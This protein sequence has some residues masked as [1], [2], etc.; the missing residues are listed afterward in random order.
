MFLFTTV[1]ACRSQRRAWQGKTVALVPTMGALHE[2]HRALIRHA[3]SV[4]DVVVVSIFVNPLQF[5]P[6]EDLAAYPRPKEQDLAS[7]EALGVDAVFYPSPL[8]MYPDGP[9]SLTRVVPPVSMTENF[10]GAFRPGHFEGVATVVLKLFSIVQPDVA[11]FGEKDAQQ[12]AIIQKM[13]RDL[14]VPVR[15]V[16]HPT[17]RDERG[18][19]LSSRNQYLKTPQE[20]EA[21]LCLSRILFGVQQALTEAGVPLPAEETLE[22]LQSAVLSPWQA[23]PVSVR[24][25][26]LAA[27]DPATFQPVAQLRPGVRVL[28]AAYVNQVRLIDNCLLT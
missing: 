4:A 27:V 19:A 12:L 18:L 24:M 9:D 15:I 3:R 1:A 2:G 21:A 26:Y 22:R 11:V 20:K 13:T 6:Q 7:C 23:G 25:Q 17:L 8:E 14:N 5:G 28:I 16:P 10:C